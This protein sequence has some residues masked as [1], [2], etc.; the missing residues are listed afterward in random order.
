MKN[1][2]AFTIN[3]NS[4]NEVSE[5]ELVNI[6][7][8]FHDLGNGEKLVNYA[9]SYFKA[10]NLL[11]DKLIDYGKIGDIGK[12]DLCILP[13][14]FLYRHSLELL[15]KGIFRKSHMEISYNHNL[16]SLY[17]KI[18]LEVSND[19]KNIIEDILKIFEKID[20]SSDAYRYP[21]NKKKK[22]FFDELNVYSLNA[23]QK[24]IR[25]I[26]CIFLDIFDQNLKEK[27]PT[28]FDSADS[29]NLSMENEIRSDDFSFFGSEYA[30]YYKKYGTYADGYFMA[31]K[32][33]MEEIDDG[34]QDLNI[35]VFL[36]CEITMELKLKSLLF[37]NVCLENIAKQDKKMNHDIRKSYNRFLK[38]IF[39][40]IKKE[41]MFTVQQYL[42]EVLNSMSELYYKASNSNEKILVKSDK[43]YKWLKYPEN[44]ENGQH[45]SYERLINCN[46]SRLFKSFEKA[47]N[48]FD[49]LDDLLNM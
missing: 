4:Y 32:I 49:Y 20:A 13:L 25:S 2:D 23:L 8:K 41:T 17:K 40:D 39:C 28:F 18:T 11:N 37:D 6:N 22:I 46:N 26:F 3:A 19:Q 42:S 14:C 1:Y 21:F 31:A 45:Q 44:S 30:E 24:N 10:A 35:P 7:K 16:Y 36:L 43:V 48:A 15:F 9:L 12:L 34:F 47:Y 29:F 33:L 38:Y 5:S 27:Y